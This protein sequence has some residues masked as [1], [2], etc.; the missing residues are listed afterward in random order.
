MTASQRN[1]ANPAMTRLLRF[2]A[3]GPVRIARTGEALK[4]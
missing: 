4:N 2:L 3:K 1:G